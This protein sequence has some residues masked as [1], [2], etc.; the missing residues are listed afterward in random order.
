MGTFHW[1]VDVV[2]LKYQLSPTDSTQ[3]SVY[4]PSVEPRNS[5]MGSTP[6][7]T[8]PQHYHCLRRSL[9]VQ[10]ETQCT[11][12]TAHRQQRFIRQCPSSL[13][14]SLPGVIATDSGWEHKSRTQVGNPKLTH[15]NRVNNEFLVNS[16]QLTLFHPAS[17]EPPSVNCI[18][19][20]TQQQAVEGH[21]LDDETSLLR[22]WLITTHPLG[23]LCGLTLF[24]S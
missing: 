9:S 1:A 14:D 18:C 5:L 16:Q 3:S 15:S 8:R 6:Q 20:S 10:T 22:K 12:Q 19:I 24:F 23:I 21:N 7:F 4:I 2:S 13:S 17:F 11:T